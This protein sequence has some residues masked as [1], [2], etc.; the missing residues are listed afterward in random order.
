MLLRICSDLHVEFWKYNKI[1]KMSR[2]VL[3]PDDR[4]KESVLIL[5]GDIGC[6]SQYPS[7]IKPILAALAPRFKGV[8]YILG[9]HEYYSGAF[10]DSYKTFWD[11][12]VLP[13]NV[14]VFDNEWRIS[15]DVAFIGSTL[16]TSMNNRDPI[17]M[18]TAERG[19]SDYEMIRKPG[20]SS[21][22]SSPNTRISAEDTVDRHES[23]AKY[24]FRAIDTFRNL[25]SKTVV[26]SHHLPSFQSVNPKFTGD[27]LNHAFASE[28]GDSIVHH[29]PTLWI[30][31][32]THDS[33]DY[34]LGDTRV[35][36]N[37]F[38]Y[39]GSQVNV[40]YNPRLFV[41]V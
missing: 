22:Y 36:C 8:I 5:A 40:K 2:T 32:H 7:T 4:D 34:V 19:M 39:H 10:W 30:H 37:P 41:E 12:K 1:P 9:N 28:L 14:H 16:W 24:I 17:A 35:V 29:S 11:D 20:A 38:G 21:P 33:C 27:S 3:P 13:K 26:I 25:N 23:S 6:L 18:F 15:D 31:G